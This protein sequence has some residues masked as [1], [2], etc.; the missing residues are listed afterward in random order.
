MAQL[1]DRDAETAAI[2][3]AV[4]DVREGEG[5]AV[6]VIGDAGLGKSALLDELVERAERAGMLVLRGRAA[7]HERDVPFGLVV[8]LLDDHVSTLHPRRID[9]LGAELAGVLPSVAAGRE[10]TQRLADDAGPSERFRYHRAL[11]SLIETLGR[12]KPLAIVLDDLHWADAASLEWVLHLL[13]RWPRVPLLFAFGLRPVDPTAALLDAARSAP[14]FLRLELQPLRREAALT[15]LADLADGSARD[16]VIED[17]A[18][19]PLFLGELARAARGGSVSLPP[20]LVAAVQLETGALPPAARALLDGAAVAGDPFDPELAAAAADIDP[21]DA[22][23]PLDTIAASGV[24]RPMG[25]GRG[26]GFRH[27]LV[28]RAIYD[29]APAAWRLGAHERVASALEARGAA[30]AAIARHVE[31]AARPG[32]ERAIE[33]LAAAARETT[34]RS[35]ATAARWYRAALGLVSADESERRVELLRPM[36]LALASAGRAAE[37]REALIETLDLLQG[38]PMSERLDV[39][40]ACIR[41]DALG[42]YYAAGRRRL[43]AAIAE[44][45]PVEVAELSLAGG[46][47]EYTA[48]RDESSMSWAEGAM[49]SAAGGDDALAVSARGLIAVGALRMGHAERALESLAAAAT[50]L[51]ALSDSALAQRLDAATNV[52]VAQL[53]AQDSPAAIRACTRGLSV[54]AGTGQDLERLLL[55]MTRGVAHNGLMALEAADRDLEA[56]EEMVRL[57]GTSHM[58]FWVLSIRALALDMHGDAVAAR[59]T[60]EEALG[61]AGGMEE[62][63]ITALGHTQAAAV[64]AESDPVRAV[65]QMQ[66]GGGPTLERLDEVRRTALLVTLVQA[67]LAAG[68]LGDAERAASALDEMARS[69]GV[70]LAPL[71]A[72]RARAELAVAAGRSDEAGRLADQALTMID[73]LDSGSDRTET[74]LIA[75][76]ALAAAGRRDEAIEQLQLAAA[77]AG[78][79]SAHKLRDAAARELRRLGTRISAEARRA[80]GG[81]R[82]VADLTERETEIAEMV[83]SGSSNKQVAAA[84]FLSEKTVESHLSRVY[85]KLGVR[86]RVE[87]ARQYESRAA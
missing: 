58:V 22:L 57:H 44:A 74:R 32:D 37:S 36:A 19:N 83:A 51:D 46:L 64:F 8:D 2:A 13:R 3:A 27:A 84:L 63:Y 54:A 73:D 18:G 4:G 39:M 35:P 7:E 5:R 21:R 80:A 62:G 69:G 48:G 66:A 20:T 24:V 61:L 68:R 26:F 17:A 49:A 77:E 25:E 12:E 14:A 23:A 79:G 55:A 29:S 85:D 67:A 82:T 33:V 87:L 10:S 72:L 75:G 43:A 53:M 11:R 50:Q 52:A 40:V 16:R 78:A 6:G 60:A 81:A 30:A 47:L 70:R 34:A 42:G 86:S 28:H 56:A 59:K 76:R 15:L 41:Q 31:H 38:R 65:T 9:E 71:R 1:V 45:G